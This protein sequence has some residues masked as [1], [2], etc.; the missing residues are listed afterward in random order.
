M[1]LSQVSRALRIS[2]EI[3]RSALA[4]GKLPSSSEPSLSPLQQQLLD[5][6]T[7]VYGQPSQPQAATLATPSSFQEQSVAGSHPGNEPQALSPSPA[8]AGPAWSGERGRGEVAASNSSP[9]SQ[10]S[11]LSQ[12]PLNR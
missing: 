12:P 7:R 1:T 5:A 6:V 4:G 3:G 9:I 11:P 8:V 2:S 10:N